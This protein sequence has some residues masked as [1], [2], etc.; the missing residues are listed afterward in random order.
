MSHKS[1]I[2]RPVAAGAWLSNFAVEIDTD[3]G[4]ICLIHFGFSDGSKFTVGRA[5]TNMTLMQLPEM[6]YGI[7]KLNFINRFNLANKRFTTGIEA[8]KLET[9]GTGRIA[10]SSKIDTSDRLPKT[11]TWYRALSAGMTK[12]TTMGT[13]LQRIYLDMVSDDT[14]LYFDMGNSNGIV[15]DPNVT[16]WSDWTPFSECAEG[17]DF[18]TQTRTCNKGDPLVDCIG[19]SINYKY[20][21]VNGYLTDWSDWSECKDDKKTRTR[22]YIPAKY[23]GNDIAD[24]NL[25]ETVDCP[26]NGYFTKWS[27]WSSCKDDKKTRTRQYIDAKNGGTDIK[28]DQY[29]LTDTA[30][31]PVDGYFTDWSN[32]SECD[33]GNQKRTRQYVAAKN[34]G[35]DIKYKE[36]ELFEDRQCDIQY[37]VVIAILVLIIV[38]CIIGFFFKKWRKRTHIETIEI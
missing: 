36:T 29:D 7:H 12:Y 9:N 15:T 34:G 38:S 27:D 10:Y 14:F 16:Y 17:V 1:Y 11:S 3:F 35:N 19:P 25:S 23:G 26:I 20:C 2:V 32:W 13:I 4:N 31:C 18:V 22:Q 30:F 28:Y 24:Y 21:P 6:P 37:Y 33:L 5:A 8:Y